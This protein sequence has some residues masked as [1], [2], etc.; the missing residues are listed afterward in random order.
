MINIQSL[1]PGD[2]VVVRGGAF[3]SK[4][5]EVGSVLRGLPSASH[6][7]VFTHKDAAGTWWGKEGRPGGVGDVDMMGYARN[8]HSVSNVLQPITDLQR[9]QIV[10]IINKLNGTPYDWAAIVE[11]AGL[12][13]G[14]RDIWQERSKNGTIPGHIVC[15]SLAAYAYDSAGVPA[16]VPTDYRHVFPADWSAFIEEQAWKFAA[17]A[18]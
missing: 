4:L 6:V 1:Q 10:A 3:T 16:P 9:K 18:T 12:A 5:I 14:L 17:K 2:I 8:T 15:S 7:A 13:F 11:D